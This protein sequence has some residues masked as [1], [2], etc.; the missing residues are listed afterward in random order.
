MSETQDARSGLPR[1]R[2]V[3]GVAVLFV[4]AAASLVLWRTGMLDRLLDGETLA[5]AVMQLGPLGPLLIIGLMTVAIVMSPFPSAPIALASGAAYGHYWSALYFAIGSETGALIAFGVSRL[6]GYDAL[7]AWL[8]TRR[9]TGMLHRFISSQKALM[10]VVFVTADAVSIFRHH[11]LCRR[12]DATQD[13]ALRRR[14]PP[15]HHSRELP[16][17]AFRRRTRLRRLATRWRNRA[18]ARPHHSA[19]RRLESYIG[20]LSISGEA[21]VEYRTEV[22]LL[23]CQIDSRTRAPKHRTREARDDGRI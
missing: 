16:A 18:R 1:P 9:P 3:A 2:I 14:D 15:W 23:R 21:P 20:A 19:A 13:L 11:Q 4:F 7:N 22:A 6:I 8:G 5:K 10:A 17:G 12:S